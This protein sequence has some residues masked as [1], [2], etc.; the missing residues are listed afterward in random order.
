MKIQYKKK[1]QRVNLIYIVFGILWLVFGGA[2][3]IAW[4][5]SKEDQFNYIGIGYFIMSLLYF[6]SYYYY[7]SI[8]YLT[9]KNGIIKENIWYGKKLKLSEIKQIKKFV[10]DYILKTDNKEMTINTQII[11]PKSLEKLN[12]ELG[13][14][15][16][17]FN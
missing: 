6:L 14:L 13:K 3:L 10:G 9:I 11:E 8:G 1:T 16:V 12:A 15:N 17:N 2:M 5:R 4:V 7:S